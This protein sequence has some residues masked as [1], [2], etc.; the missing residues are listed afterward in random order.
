[1]YP[2]K[3]VVTS[4]CLASG[5]IGATGAERATGEELGDS[6]QESSSAII[7]LIKI[8]HIEFIKPG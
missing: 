7:T 3:W 6:K 2:N 4:V 1:M 8:T 5:G